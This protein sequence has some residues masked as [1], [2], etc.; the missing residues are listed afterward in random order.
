[1]APGEERSALTHLAQWEVS[2]AGAVG[3]T[4]SVR[5]RD[6]VGSAARRAA[7]SL[8]PRKPAPPVMR[9]VVIGWR[10]I[11]WVLRRRNER[12]KDSVLYYWITFEPPRSSCFPRLCTRV[13]SVRVAR[14][15]PILPLSDEL[16]LA[17]AALQLYI[18]NC[19]DHNIYT[20]FRILLHKHLPRG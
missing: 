14:H 19:S 15:Y 1:M 12:I 13:I 18:V 4:T 9:M 7:A 11:W 10:C 3:S 8:W 6:M 20:S 16:H 5:R 17:K 2:F